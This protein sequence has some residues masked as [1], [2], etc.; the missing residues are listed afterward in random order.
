MLTAASAFYHVASHVWAP[1]TSS[2]TEALSGESNRA[3]EVLQFYHKDTG[4]AT[5]SSCR[6][7]P[8]SRPVNKA[9]DADTVPEYDGSCNQDLSCTVQLERVCLTRRDF[10]P[11]EP[12]SSYYSVGDPSVDVLGLGAECAD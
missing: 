6:F 3:R 4:S 5:G 1:Q 8:H 7:L 10:S 2:E 11:P 9:W 12:N